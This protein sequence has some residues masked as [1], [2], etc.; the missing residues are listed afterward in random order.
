MNGIGLVVWAVITL[1]SF[2]LSFRS[3]YISR[4]VRIAREFARNPEKYR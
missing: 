2:V 3:M 4:Q 1:A